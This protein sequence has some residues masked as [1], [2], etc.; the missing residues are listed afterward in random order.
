MAHMNRYRIFLKQLSHFFYNRMGYGVALFFV[1]LFTSYVYGA[2][3][4]NLGH[5]FGSAVTRYSIF[6]YVG[7]PLSELSFY[8]NSAPFISV[9]LL[10]DLSTSNIK[11]KGYR[12]DTYGIDL[13]VTKSTGWF[14]DKDF[15][16]GREILFQPITT[17]QLDIYSRADLNC[18]S[19]RMFLHVG[20][21]V[22]QYSYVRFNLQVGYLY[23]NEVH[24]VFDASQWEPSNVQVTHIS[25]KVDTSG[26]A[27]SNPIF[28][29]GEVL[30]YKLTH[31]G[32]ILG[33]QISSHFKRFHWDASVLWTPLVTITDRDDHLLINKVSQSVHEGTFVNMDIG[34]T[35]LLDKNWAIFSQF[36]F[37]HIYSNSGYQ[38][39][40]VYSDSSLDTMIN[41]IPHS[42]FRQQYGLE[43][44]VR[45]RI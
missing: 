15:D 26:S 41:N 7:T 23:S 38:T 44:G 20:K 36:K 16:I 34:M 10:K 2:L 31:Q 17:N 14:E 25:D 18:Q 32:P 43:M 1:G 40:W 6:P 3:S 8:S 11:T 5:Q 29:P 33:A 39:Q 9:K 12:F 24:S 27:F 19:Y 42:I 30:R 45:Y 21:T 22:F 13:F 4:L 37:I 35:Y 28:L